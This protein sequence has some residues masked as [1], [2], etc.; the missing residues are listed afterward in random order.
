MNGKAAGNRRSG[1]GGSFFAWIRR[2]L[3]SSWFNSALTVLLLYGICRVAVPLV[4]WLLVDAQW[5]GTTA[6]SCSDHREACWPFVWARIDQFLYGLYPATELLRIKLGVALG[7]AL[8]AASL[9]GQLRKRRR[10]RAVLFSLYLPVTVYLFVGGAGLPLVETRM[11][12]GLFL[13]L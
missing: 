13:N 8:G 2:N 11:W 4:D 1:R 3:F 9:S 12:G 6:A 5:A 10:L 7:L